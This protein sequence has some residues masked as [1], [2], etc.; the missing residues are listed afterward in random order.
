M[1]I[2]CTLL[3]R[4]KD[5]S[6]HHSFFTGQMPFLLPNQQRQRTEGPTYKTAELTGQNN[7]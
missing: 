3:Q 5:A 1:Q 2:I 6:P 7:K 4:D